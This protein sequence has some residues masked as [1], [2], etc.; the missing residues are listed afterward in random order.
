[1]RVVL[2]SASPRRRELLRSLFSDFETVVADIDETLDEGVPP[3]DEVEILSVRKGRA[4]ADKLSDPEALIISSDTLVEL[5]GIP[6]GKPQD[7]R[8]AL[9]MLESLSGREHRVHTGVAV[10]YRG[11]VYSGVDTTAVFFRGI[12]AE[13]AVEYVNGGEPMD[14][15]GA[16]GI[17]GEGGKFVEHIEGDFDTVMGLSM[18][19]VKELVG[20]ALSSPACG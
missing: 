17:Q 6:L 4:V 12:S 1:M 15:A 20:K 14:K 11:R 9:R 5:S 19:L 2:A 3:R 18:R 8:D 16:Y 13:E 7:E 10:H